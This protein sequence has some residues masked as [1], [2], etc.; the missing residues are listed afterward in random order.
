MKCFKHLCAKLIFCL[1]VGVIGFATN[2]KADEL[3]EEAMRAAEARAQDVD[4]LSRLVQTEGGTFD[5]RVCVA[6]TAL[7]RV[8]SPQFPNTVKENIYAPS[9]YAKP[10]KGEVLPENLLAAEYAMQLW[11]SGMS[12]SVLPDGYL[13]FAGN[14]KRNRFRNAQGDHY[15]APDI[16][17]FIPY[18]TTQG[19]DGALTS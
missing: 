11:E 10:A 18:T 19:P 3:T 2:V 17:Q 9:Q 12:Y 16:A 7:H 8:D 14:G 4:I 13:Y 15:D 5:D 1:F 6:L